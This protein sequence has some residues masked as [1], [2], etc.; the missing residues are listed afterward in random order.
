MEAEFQP[1]IFRSFS[2]AFLQDPVAGIID[3]GIN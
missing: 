2:D 3:L 1:E